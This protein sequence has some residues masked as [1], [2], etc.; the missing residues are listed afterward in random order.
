MSR[1]EQKTHIFWRISYS[2]NFGGP[3]G[4]LITTELALKL[5]N[6]V[7]DTTP[8]SHPLRRLALDLQRD[9]IIGNTRDKNERT[10]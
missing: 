4:K 10:L 8:P 6:D 9:I 2:K 3:S 7:L 5:L 1:I